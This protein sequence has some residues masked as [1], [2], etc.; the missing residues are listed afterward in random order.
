ML[1]PCAAKVAC[2]V[3]RAGGGSNPA[4]LT[5]RGAPEDACAAV[6]VWRPTASRVGQHRLSRISLSLRLAHTEGHRHPRRRLAYDPLCLAADLSCP[7]KYPGNARPI[8]PQVLAAS[9]AL[10]WCGTAIMALR[11]GP[12]RVRSCYF[13]TE[14]TDVLAMFLPVRLLKVRLH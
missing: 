9:G 10:A 7:V 12:Y 4:S 13:R 8:S 5:R 11:T 6:G 2:T 1:E 3:L 14:V